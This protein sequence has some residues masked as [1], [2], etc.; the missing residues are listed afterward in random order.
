MEKKR[1]W[2]RDTLILLL[3]LQVLAQFAKDIW[4]NGY[5]VGLQAGYQQCLQQRPQPWKTV[6]PP[7]EIY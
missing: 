7:E 2:V 5:K 4:D 1:P 6:A 3:L